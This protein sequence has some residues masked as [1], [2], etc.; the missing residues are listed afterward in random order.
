PG[1]LALAVGQRRQV[2]LDARRALEDELPGRL[3]LVKGGRT[4]GLVRQG[5]L[6][7]AAPDEWSRRPPKGEGVRLRAAGAGMLRRGREAGQSPPASARSPRAAP[8]NSK[9]S[10]R[11][12]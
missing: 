11:F 6:A 4:R 3:E 5:G 9:N 7:H 2:S 8:R 1:R 12:L 10:A